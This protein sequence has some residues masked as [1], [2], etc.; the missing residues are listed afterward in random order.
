MIEVFFVVCLLGLLVLFFGPFDLKVEED[1][2]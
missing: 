1:D 2:V